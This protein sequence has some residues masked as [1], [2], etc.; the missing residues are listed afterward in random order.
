VILGHEQRT[1]ECV[2]GSAHFVL[3][4]QAIILSGGG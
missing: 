2:H 4:A 3:Q 1:P